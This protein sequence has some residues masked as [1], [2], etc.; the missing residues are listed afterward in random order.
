VDFIGRC[1]ALGLD[2][3]VAFPTV[4]SPTRETQA[5]FAADCRAAGVK[6]AV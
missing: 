3:L 4:V 2:R 1:A 5:A 6:L